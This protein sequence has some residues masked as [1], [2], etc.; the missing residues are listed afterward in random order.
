VVL[1][2]HAPNRT[3]EISLP[4]QNTEETMKF[5]MIR[6]VALTAS[7]LPMAGLPLRRAGRQPRYHREPGQCRQRVVDRVQRQSG[8]P[9]GVLCDNFQFRSVV[10]ELDS[11]DTLRAQEDAWAGVFIGAE[12][13]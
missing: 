12:R 4:G 13:C 7:L 1:T 11:G 2:A 9:P 10:V 3:L 6:T 5:N 8:G